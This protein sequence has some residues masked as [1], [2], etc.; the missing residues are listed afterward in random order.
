MYVQ[1]N[2]AGVFPIRCAEY[3]GEYHSLMIGQVEVVAKEGMNCDEDFG[4]YFEHEELRE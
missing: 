2:E 4:I 1:P 3:C